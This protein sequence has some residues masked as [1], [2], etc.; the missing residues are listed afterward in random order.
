[1]AKT[2]SKSPTAK[3]KVP[4]IVEYR[5]GD[6]LWIRWLLPCDMATVAKMDR[7]EFDHESWVEKDFAVFLK[8]H[9]TRL[10][11]VATAHDHVVGYMVYEWFK[12][13]VELVRLCVLPEVRR[14]TIA[15]QM[16]VQL[17]ERL[18]ASKKCRHLAANVPDH[19]LP[20]QLFLKKEE[21]RALHVLSEEDGNDFYR[22]IYTF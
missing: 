17:K 21:F 4:E 11:F 13:R 2:P 12:N 9:H 6:P 5:S 16:I 1:M 8:G 14:Q 22:M 7:L 19:L 20:M 10:G 18:R 15:T 3:S